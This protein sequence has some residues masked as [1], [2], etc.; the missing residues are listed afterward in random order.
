MGYK[1]IIIECV[2]SKGVPISPVV[3]LK[4]KEH[5]APWYQEPNLP[6]LDA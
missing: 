3:I 5:Q 1:L 2:S 4:V 6:G